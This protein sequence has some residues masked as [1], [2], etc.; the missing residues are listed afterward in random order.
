M[1]GVDVVPPVR[2]D[3][4]VPL[5]PQAA[6][7]L[8]TARFDAFW[9]RTHHIGSAPF[10]EAVLEPHPGGRWYERGTDGSEC[11]WG[12]VLVWEPPGRL[13]LNWQIT[14]E[15]TFDPAL[16]TEVEITFTPIAENATRVAL[17][18]RNLDRFGDAQTAVR[19]AIDS[20]GGW[21]GIMAAYHDLATA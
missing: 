5:S 18:H 3:V 8:F 4:V 2:H 14:G 12:R 1:I 20:P 9:P 21:P 10:A 11:D 16:T 13:I 7:D 6:F 15:W 19:T 17:E